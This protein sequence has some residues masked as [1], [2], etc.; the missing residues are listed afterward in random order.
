MNSLFNSPT[1]TEEEIISLIKNEVEE[2][3]NLDFK[4]AGSLDKSDSKKNEISKDVSAF[5]NSTGGTI[6][7][8]IAEKEHKAHSL[9]PIN[10]N[11]FTKEWL[12]QVINSR[13]QRKIEGIRIIP[14]R[15]GGQVDQTVYVVNIPESDNTPHMAFDNK[16]YKRY[17]FLSAQME[18]YEVRQLYYRQGKSKII[19]DAILI[20]PHG[21]AQSGGKLIS[22]NFSLGFQIKNIG[23]TI[24]NQYKLEAWIPEFIYNQYPQSANPFSKYFIRKDANYSVFSVPNNSPLFQGEI[25]T[26]E[27]CMIKV[28]KGSLSTIA[29]FPLIRKLYYSNG[30][31]ESEILLSEHLSYAGDLLRIDRFE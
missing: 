25:T 31:E 23:N 30:T 2:S 11:E 9:S 22:V 20:S 16:Y 6:I 3:I 18:E 17:N 8:G 13:I 29:N 21:A 7:Y 24:E 19:M 28:D 4:S 27:T 12:E 1:I 5:A 15:I 10:G 26:I 14:V